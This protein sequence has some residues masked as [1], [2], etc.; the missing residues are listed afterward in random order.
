MDDQVDLS[1]TLFVL[2]FSNSFVLVISGQNE[3]ASCNLGAFLCQECAS[4]HRSL[5]VD[6]SRIKSV[7][8]DNWEDNQVKVCDQLP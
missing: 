6:I 4:I 2:L 7:K 1:L 3:W 8:L 5:G